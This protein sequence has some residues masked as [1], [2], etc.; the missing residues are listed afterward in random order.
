MPFVKQWELLRRVFSV[1][2]GAVKVRFGADR[3]K[4]EKSF[5]EVWCRWEIYG[6][7]LT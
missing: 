6:L 3:V 5:C 2:F 4:I 7:L 1:R